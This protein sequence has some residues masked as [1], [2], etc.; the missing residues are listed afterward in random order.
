VDASFNPGANGIVY[1]LAIQADGKIL[2]GG[3][4]TWL[5]DSSR[6]Y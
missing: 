6:S 1:S 3:A 5:G 2:V 4:F